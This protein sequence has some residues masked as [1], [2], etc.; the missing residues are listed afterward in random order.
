LTELEQYITSYFGI[1]QKNLA[2]VTALFKSTE[3]KKGEYYLKAGQ[4][5]EKMS[6]IQSGYV[7]IFA[8]LEQ[9]EITQW[10]STKGYFITE[11]NSFIFKQRSRYNMQALSDC[12]LFTI[13]KEQYAQLNTVEPNWSEM[14]K[15]FIAG[16]FVTLENRVFNHLS[17]TAEERYD[18]LFEFNKEFFNHVPQQYLASMLGMSP[19]TFSRIRSKKTS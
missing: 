17:L 13:E 10:I 19:E 5:C 2:K 16:C 7:R 15:R 14:E 3:L 18:Q 4:F 12:Q 11:L 1:E 8:K 6:F 9:K